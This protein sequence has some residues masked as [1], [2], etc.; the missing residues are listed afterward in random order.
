MI[1]NSFRLEPVTPAIGAYVH[2]VDLASDLSDEDIGRLRQAWMEHVVLFFRD[3]PLDCGRL[4]ALARRF[5]AP[6][7]HPQGDIEGYPGILRIHVD[8][9]SKT[10]PGRTWHSDVSCDELPPMGSILHL[11]Q[12]P[13]TGGDTLFANMY[14]AYEA[15]SEPMQTFLDGLEALHASRPNVEGYYRMNAEQ[16][17]DK[18]FPEA[19]HP[20]VCRHPE[21]GRKALFVNEI[22]TQHIVGLEPAEGRSV[23][24]FLYRHIASPKF[25]C[26]FSWQ[27]NS[28]AM[29]DNRCCQHIAMW[30]Y[31]PQ[32]RSGHRATI[33]GERPVAAA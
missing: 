15:L 22:F 28:V 23:L 18:S 17:R 3:Q 14:A 27:V 13:D 25:H 21:T 33:I 4:Q 8:G 6:H 24:D 12:I 11:H 32:T 5:G 16:L 7:I 29:W 1:S 10:Q 19:V 26:R 31:Y 9:D 2:G 20:V 30:D